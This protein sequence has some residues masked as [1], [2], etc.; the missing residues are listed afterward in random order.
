[1]LQKFGVT[2]DYWTLT[3]SRNPHNGLM[4]KT[5]LESDR[6]F[7]RVSP[8]RNVAATAP[9]FH[10]ASVDS[11]QQAVRIMAQV[12]PGQ[13]LDEPATEQWRELYDAV[14]GRCRRADRYTAQSMR[15]T[16]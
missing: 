9:Y 10:D 15:V 11:L 7:F 14:S 12:Q 5:G 3:K 1:M 16:G 2:E 4:E 8:L 13:T 6:Y